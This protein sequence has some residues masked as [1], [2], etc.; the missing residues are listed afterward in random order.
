M[1]KEPLISTRRSDAHRGPQLGAAERSVSIAAGGAL[2]VRGLRIGGVSGLLQIG[3]GACAVVRGATG[4]CPVKGALKHT[5]FENEFQGSH[6]WKDSNAISR[7]VTIDK[8]LPDV[9]AFI[10][11]PEN[12]A[13][14][15][16]WVDNVESISAVTSVWSASAPLGQTLKWSLELVDD[17]SDTL[18]WATVPDSRWQHEVTAHF[19]EAPGN[20]GTE[21]KVI[22]VGKT[23]FGKVGYAVAK[24]LA[25]FTDKMLL[26]LLHSVKQQLETGEVSTNCLRAD[27]SPDFYVH[28]VAANA[29]TSEENP[30]GAVK[31]GVV[32][33]GGNLQ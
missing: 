31:T 4:K 17:Q 11:R 15:I 30:A 27:R 20:R 32:L 9:M 3:L 28:P 19:M 26:N 7:S 5:P 12:V 8:P 22:I 18:R 2:L 33:E 14:L 25:Q 13:P 23:P 21:V 1:A 10:R 6:G 29:L 16:P 24:S